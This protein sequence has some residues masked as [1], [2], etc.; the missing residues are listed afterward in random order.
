MTRR[1]KS[2]T[3]RKS[4]RL[5]TGLA[6]GLSVLVLTASFLWHQRLEMKKQV[7]VS[8]PESS[9]TVED[10]IAGFGHKVNARL[11]PAFQSA[12]VL[13]P[14]PKMLWVAFKEERQL[15]ILAGTS[16]GPWIPVLSYQIEGA[17]GGPG[18]KLREGDR[19]VPEGNYSLELLNPNSRFHVSI[20]IGYPGLHDLARARS[21]GRCENS[22]G[23]DIMIHGGSASI[24]C[25]AMGDE[26]AEELFALA[27]ATGLESIELLITPRDLRDGV[28]PQLSANAPSWTL[29]LHEEIRSQLEMLPIPRPA[30]AESFVKDDQ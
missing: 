17:S 18:P 28:M 12:G 21:E 6:V 4:M 5:V 16:E 26:A 9:R 27:H 7:S 22:L 19:Q 15:H 13:F 20:R 3:V 11:Q 2:K 8:P 30:V 24:G 1:V 29:E 10:R 25:L 14:P 23:G